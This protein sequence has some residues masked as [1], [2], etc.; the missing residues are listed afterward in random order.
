MNYIGGCMDWIWM[1]WLGYRVGC[2]GENRIC[3]EV[4]SK[5]YVNPWKWMDRNLGRKRKVM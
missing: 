4:M 1:I 5:I 3:F 2:W